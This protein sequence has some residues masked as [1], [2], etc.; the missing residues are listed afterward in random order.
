MEPLTVIAISVALFFAFWN[1]FT[2]AAN[3]ISTVVATRALKPLQ[4]VAL[5]AAG[6]FAGI[7]LGV[8]VAK[9]IGKGIVD[10]NIVSADLVLAALI[11]GLIWDVFTYYIAV[12]VSE[13]HVLIGGLVGA[14]IAAGGFS[15][16]NLA[17]IRDR[18]VVP[19]IL[20]PAVA[21]V[22]AFLFAGLMMRG[23]RR[24]SAEKV[25]GAFKYLQICSSFFFS[26]THGANDAQKTVGLIT[27][28][29]L[30]AGVLTSFSV[31]LWV[32]L[33]AHAAISIGTFFGGWR[34]VKTMGMRITDLKPFQ[35]FVAETSAA[36]IL[37]AT[38]SHGFP[39]STTHAI[40]GS[41][42]GVGATKRLSA[43]RWGVARKIIATWIVTI[44]MAALFAFFVYKGF[45]FVF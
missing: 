37:A 3:A 40:S 23:L 4:A 7:F 16:V 35:G 6:N 25:N 1:G 30:Y 18:V 42:M 38:A 20:S 9:T 14:G 31:P 27:A 11:G 5:S 33:A 21:L 36:L 8:E 44:P 17:G 22:V 45:A 29:L 10:S 34:I 13:S 15:V 41:I 2:D 43:V 12:P 32:I 28:V 39:V 26:V 19:M 24:F